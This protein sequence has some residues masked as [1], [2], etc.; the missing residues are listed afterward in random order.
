MMNYTALLAGISDCIDQRGDAE[1]L[2]PELA[3]LAEVMQM[4]QLAVLRRKQQL[5]SHPSKAQCGPG[6]LANNRMRAAYLA[7]GL[8]CPAKLER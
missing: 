6:T 8:P 1:K 5:Q 2:T 4:L 7:A 3:Q